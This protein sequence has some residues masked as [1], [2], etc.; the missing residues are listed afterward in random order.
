[1][2]PNT[3]TTLYLLGYK[4]TAKSSPP[5]S[6]SKMK[7]TKSNLENLNEE[8]DEL[9]TAFYCVYPEK[10]DCVICHLRDDWTTINVVTDDEYG[11]GIMFPMDE[12]NE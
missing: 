6:P 3:S 4:P 11:W 9:N 8:G 12:W 2:H 10:C 7:R 5:P 1:M